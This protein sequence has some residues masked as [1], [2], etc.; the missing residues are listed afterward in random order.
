[1]GEHKGSGLSIM[2]ELLAGALTGSGA[3]GPGTQPFCNGMLSIYLSPDH[4]TGG[5][6]EHFHREV[7]DYVD[8]L[9]AARPAAGV[10][11]VLAPGDPERARR[12]VHLAHGL[13]LPDDSWASIVDAAAS[14]G[15]TVTVMAGDVTAGDGGPAAL[16]W[17]RS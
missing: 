17:S 4:L 2:C 12:A 1:M 15:V 16:T 3:A 11:E 6:T 14:V 13:E 10:H 7:I 8:W 5:R 9:R